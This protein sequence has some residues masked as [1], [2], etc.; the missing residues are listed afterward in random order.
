MS[1]LKRSPRNVRSPRSTAAMVKHLPSTVAALLQPG[2]GPAKLTKFDTPG[3]E[4]WMTLTEFLWNIS[5]VQ[6]QEALNTDFIQ[7]I[8]SGLLDPTNYGGY[9]VQDAVYCD[10][11]TGCYEKAESKATDED[12]KKFIA[13]RI[14]SYAEYTEIMFKEWYI[15]HPKGISMGDAAASYSEFELDV[16]T[17]EEPFYL[18]IAML[19][20]EKL[21]GWLAQEIKSGIND[22]NVYSF[23][24]QDNLPGSHT[25]ANYIDENAEKFKVDLKK[26]MKIYKDGMQCEV[27]FFT[28][29]TIEEVN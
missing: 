24:I 6:A 16:A 5:Q 4:K 12:L 19:P 27:D 23:W 10:N 22:T 26:A 29:G 25:L 13:A 28:S 3:G 17:T 8:K 11:A 21:W 15:K 18:L 1:A 14:E 9:T 2:K 20:C 7:G